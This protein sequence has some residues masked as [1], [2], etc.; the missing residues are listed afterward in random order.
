M[1]GHLID[2]SY[3]VRTYWHG[4]HHSDEY[5]INNVQDVEPVLEFNHRARQSTHTKK[6]HFRFVARVP[7]VVEM[8]WEKEQPGILRDINACLKKLDDPEWKYLRTTP[9]RLHHPKFSMRANIASD[10]LMVA[11]DEAVEEKNKEVLKAG[12]EP[13]GV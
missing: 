1:G 7:H 6:T 13:V 10:A 12:L 3:N 5:T 11:R 4:H 2:D 8:I 9:N